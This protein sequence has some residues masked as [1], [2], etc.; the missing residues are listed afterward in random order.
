MASSPEGELDNVKALCVCMGKP[1]KN[2]V[3]D[4]LEGS[5]YIQSNRALTL[6]NSYLILS[7]K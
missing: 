1:L 3:G 4:D 5:F 2:V 7:L 6:T